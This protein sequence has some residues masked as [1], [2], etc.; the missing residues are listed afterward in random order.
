MTEVI[1]IS[2][3]K[4]ANTFRIGFKV[5]FESTS[6]NSEAYFMIHS[7]IMGDPCFDGEFFRNCSGNGICVR[8]SPV[9]N[10]TC[11]CF[12]GFIQSN[13]CKQRDYCN[14]PIPKVRLIQF[15]DVE[16]TKIYFLKPN[17]MH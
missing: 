3:D 9:S 14:F 4:M 13:D 2:V 7:L 15:K 11:K 8:N 5:D 10:F 16:S 12:E 6:K 17:L 1:S